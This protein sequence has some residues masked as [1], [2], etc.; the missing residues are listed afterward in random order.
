MNKNPPSPKPGKTSVGPKPGASA[1]AAPG[2]AGH[3]WKGEAV[4]E[5]A[6]AGRSGSPEDAAR[7]AEGNAPVAAERANDASSA[8][9]T[10]D[11]KHPPRP[12]AALDDEAARRENEEEKRQAA[13]EEH[14][15][16][17]PKHA[18]HGRL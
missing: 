16:D 12:D 4:E 1:A 15:A 7:R 8:P 13:A 11:W 5:P 17:S 3:N 18:P 9:G 14:A 6:V 2:A 10:F